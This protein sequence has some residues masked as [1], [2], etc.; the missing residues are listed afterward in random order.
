MLRCWVDLFG[1]GDRAVRAMSWVFGIGAAAV[2]FDA[3][4]RA[5]GAWRGLA[6]AGIMIFAQAQID[7]SQAARPYTM[8]VFLGAALCDAIIAVQYERPSAGKLALIAGATG[9]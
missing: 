4:R 7:F 9:R 5:A 3:V 8:M 1:Q 2:L 6:A